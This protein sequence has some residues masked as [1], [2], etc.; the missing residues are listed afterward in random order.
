L[1]VAL[2]QLLAGNLLDPLLAHRYACR[3]EAT[4]PVGVDHGESIGG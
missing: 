1:R 3:Q 2:H 4:V